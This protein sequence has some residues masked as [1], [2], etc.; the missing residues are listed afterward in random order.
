MHGTFC[1]GGEGASGALDIGARGDKVGMGG[2]VS[3]HCG[4]VGRPRCMV[5]F[6]TF[7]F[8]YISQFI[9]S[10]LYIYA[11]FTPLIWP[12]SL[13]F[14]SLYFVQNSVR[15][16][17]TLNRRLPDLMSDRRRLGL[18]ERSARS[19]KRTKYQSKPQSKNGHSFFIFPST[20]PSH[21]LGGLV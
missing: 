12:S 11:P 6:S 2:K 20:S 3:G 18:D 1:I 7:S 19:A 16:H 15:S 10:S 17:W 9:D 4:R 8:I 5:V 21:K 14:S 13:Y